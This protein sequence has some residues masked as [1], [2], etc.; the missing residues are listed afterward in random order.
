M[1][2][3]LLREGA[4]QPLKQEGTFTHSLRIEWVFAAFRLEGALPPE[5]ATSGPFVKCNDALFMTLTN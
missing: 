4:P 3:A 5:A 1:V 2:F